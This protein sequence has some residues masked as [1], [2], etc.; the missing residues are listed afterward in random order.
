MP[1]MN[2]PGQ[3]R[4]GGGVLNTSEDPALS[5]KEAGNGNQTEFG[6]PQ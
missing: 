1:K 3:S 5:T 6:K 2:L 4:H